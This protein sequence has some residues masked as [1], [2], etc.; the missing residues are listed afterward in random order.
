[1]HQYM[2]K[3]ICIECTK[4]I[5]SNLCSNRLKNYVEYAS[6]LERDHFERRARGEAREKARRKAR[7]KDIDER[8]RNEIL[9]KNDTNAKIS[10]NKIVLFAHV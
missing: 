9:R 8:R 4:H 10:I 3:Y 7:E 5:C 6:K 2:H 1:M